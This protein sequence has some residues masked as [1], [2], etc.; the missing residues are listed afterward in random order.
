LRD[1][2]LKKHGP[3]LRQPWGW[4]DEDVQVGL[5]ILGGEAD[6]GPVADEGA[7]QVVGGVGVAGVTELDRQVQGTSTSLTRMPASSTAQIV[8]PGG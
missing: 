7:F 4:I 3:E 8:L 2:F 1:V 5:A 6:S